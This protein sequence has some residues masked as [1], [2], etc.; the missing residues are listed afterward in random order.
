MLDLILAWGSLDGALTMLVA[1]FKGEPL[2]V[3]VDR[4]GKEKA[5]CKLLEIARI[6]ESDKRTAAFAKKVKA[7]KKQYEKYARAR[8]RIAHS[9]CCG[10]LLS[11]DKYIVFAVAEPEGDNQLAV[12]AI[13]IKCMKDA[14]KFGQNLRVFAFR[15]SEKIEAARAH[16]S[17]T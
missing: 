9:H 10:Y 14:T 7:Q 5:S 1:A 6:L 13:P 17:Q 4:I 15:T 12:E 2:H 3:A 8:N 11:D 16:P